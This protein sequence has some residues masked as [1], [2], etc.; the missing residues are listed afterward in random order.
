MNIKYPLKAPKYD[1]LWYKLIDE[2]TIIAYKGL[3]FDKTIQ[4]E[5]I[6]ADIR[7]RKCS[8]ANSE[9]ERDHHLD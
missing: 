9:W 8:V 1:S 3:L 2:S 7:F 6:L 4:R 5:E